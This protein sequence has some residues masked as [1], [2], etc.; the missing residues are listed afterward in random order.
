MAKPTVVICSLS[1]ALTTARIKS[2]PAKNATKASASGSTSCHSAGRSGSRRSIRLWRRPGSLRDFVEALDPAR[3]QRIDLRPVM[4]DE[5]AH[6]V[7][8]F[9]RQAG[10][11]GVPVD[12]YEKVALSSASCTSF[13]ITVSRY[14]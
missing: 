3:P 4:P 11:R 10:S 14:L 9:H 8:A 12:R 2:G 13:P 7:E 1:K 5:F 6:L